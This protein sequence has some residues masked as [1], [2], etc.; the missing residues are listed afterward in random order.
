M[1]TLR[2]DRPRPVSNSKQSKVRQEGL[3]RL[4]STRLE[5]TKLAYLKLRSQVKWQLREICR[6]KRLADR[7]NPQARTRLPLPL[8]L[9][10]PPPPLILPP[11]PVPQRTDITRAAVPTP[12]RFKAIKRSHRLKATRPKPFK[13]E[14]LR[15]RSEVRWRLKDLGFEKRPPP[16]PPPPPVVPTRPIQVHPIPV[17][18]GLIPALLWPVSVFHTP[19]SPVAPTPRRTNW[20]TSTRISVLA[21]QDSPKRA[22]R[23]RRRRRLIPDDPMV[24]VEFFDPPP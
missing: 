11:L 23:P 2:T 24:D 12:K 10:P 9:P 13:M 15:L 3:R 22:Y 16:P 1:S 4:K 17:M 7:P 8:S 6:R 21:S 20:D 14:Y 5:P 18:I 19:P